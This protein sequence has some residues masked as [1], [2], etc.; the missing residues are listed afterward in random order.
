MSITIT[1]PAELE[2]LVLKQAHISGKAVEEYALDLLKKGVEL[3]DPWEGFADV[4]EQIK[5]TGTTEVE[6]EAKI[7]AAVAEVGARTLTPYELVADL[8]G[9]VDS[10]VPDPASPPIQTAFGQHLLEKHQQQL[11]KLRGTS[12]AQPNQPDHH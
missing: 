2:P 5:A 12:P 3:A 1:I 10:S 4:R 8:I 7:D 11:E 6:L 9:S